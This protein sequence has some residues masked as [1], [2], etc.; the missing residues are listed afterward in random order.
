MVAG[1]LEF[2]QPSKELRL[3]PYFD[4]YVVGSHPRDVV[5]PGVAYDRALSNGQAGTVATLLIG[6]VVS[7]I[8]H[9]RRTGKKVA[10]TVEPFVELNATQRRE[11]DDQIARVGE[12]SLATPTLTLGTVAAGKHL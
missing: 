4:A 8:W 9:Q 10:I 6:G 3:L 5:Y 1:D 2:P 7:G 12:I 11:L